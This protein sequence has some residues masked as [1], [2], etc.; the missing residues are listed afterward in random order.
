MAFLLVFLHHGPFAGSLP[1]IEFMN[2]NG[3]IGVEIFFAI[4]SY[5]FFYLLSAEHDK[6]GT[7][8]ISKFYARRAI[9]ILPL[10]WVF[11]ALMLLFFYAPGQ[12]HISRAL[13]TALGIDNL[14]AWSHGYNPLPFSA[15]LWT[16][17]FE[18]QVYLVIPAAFLAYRAMGK[19]TFLWLLAA[20]AVYCSALRIAFVLS[21]ASHPTV[22]VSPF[23]RPEAIILGIALSI[24]RPT[25]NPMLSLFGSAIS[26]ATVALL[27]PIT[28]GL[29]SIAVYPFSALGACFLL[30]FALRQK[31]ASAL[32]SLR[33]LRYLGAISF[34]LYV[35]HFF[36][37]FLAEAIVFKAQILPQTAP[38]FYA[39]WLALTVAI[40]SISYWL[41]ELPLL[42]FK[43][44]LA[45]VGGRPADSPGKRPIDHPTTHPPT[46]PQ[47]TAPSAR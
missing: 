5:L 15:H 9:R 32:F 22:W 47:T 27:P 21:G 6:T 28:H 26:F 12:S 45:V 33:P 8:S 46:H 34:G 3:W 11:I 25:W 29:G 13:G 20:V 24:S 17:S 18:L 4:S 38:V 41:F 42:K 44:R 30:D 2:R 37:Q 1:I 40:A 23:L 14:L 31:L 19:G 10:M 36:A 39:V 16:L 7:V 35:F 43:S